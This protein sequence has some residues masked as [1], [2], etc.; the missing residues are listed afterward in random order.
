[1]VVTDARPRHVLLLHKTAASR[2]LCTRLGYHQRN[3]HGTARRK[4]GKESIAPEFRIL[5]IVVQFHFG[6]RKIKYR[7][8]SDVGMTKIGRIAG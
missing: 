2:Q 8:L 7:I 6:Q 3:Y 4:S 5:S 1:M